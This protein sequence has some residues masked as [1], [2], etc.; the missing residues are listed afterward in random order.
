MRWWGIRAMAA[1]LQNVLAVLRSHER[2]LR[3]QGVLQPI[4]FFEYARLKL[5]VN[6]LLHE[7]SDVPNPLELK[8][9]LRESIVRDAVQAF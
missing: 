4:G 5:Y 6:S 7:T 3:E 2:E 1:E 9:L 8:P